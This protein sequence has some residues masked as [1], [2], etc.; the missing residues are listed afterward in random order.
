ITA[1]PVAL[2]I[3][4]AHPITPVPGKT[5]AA[6][7][8]GGLQALQELIVRPVWAPP[9]PASDGEPT[10]GEVPPL[11]TPHGVTAILEDRARD[12]KALCTR[13]GRARSSRRAVSNTRALKPRPSATCS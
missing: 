2:Y 10:L 8:F 11:P 7:R 4:Q 13:Q 3:F 5:N 12:K 1:E 9:P 6:V